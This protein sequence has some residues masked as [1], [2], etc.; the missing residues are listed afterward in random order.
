MAFKTQRKVV[1]AQ[2]MGERDSNVSRVVSFWNNRGWLV[3]DKRGLPGNRAHIVLI[4]KAAR[5][6]H[7]SEL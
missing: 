2:R 5:K 1:T 3:E 7:D 4:R 6:T